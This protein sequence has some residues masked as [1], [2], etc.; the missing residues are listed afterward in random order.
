MVIALIGD[1]EVAIFA[2]VPHCMTAQQFI[3]WSCPLDLV[4]TYTG[5][6]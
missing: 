4:R 3:I 5:T 1:A 2:N 6:A